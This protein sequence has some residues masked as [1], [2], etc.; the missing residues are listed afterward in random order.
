MKQINA[1]V[2]E[3]GKLWASEKEA[4]K[5]EATLSKKQDIDEFLNSSDSPYEGISQRAISRQA[6]VCWEIWKDKQNAK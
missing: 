5:H 1:F 2:T 3:D 4:Q 6:I